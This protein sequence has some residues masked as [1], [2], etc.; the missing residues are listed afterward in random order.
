MSITKLN[1]FNLKKHRVSIR[2]IIKNTTLIQCKVKQINYYLQYPIFNMTN[3]L[4]TEKI[5]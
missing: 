5:L 3:H 4:K 1:E 2:L